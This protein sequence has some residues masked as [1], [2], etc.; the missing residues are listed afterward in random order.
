MRCLGARALRAPLRSC[1]YLPS[2]RR[3]AERLL[4]SSSCSSRRGCPWC[5][6]WD[7]EIAPIYGKTDLGRRATLRRVDISAPRPADLASIAPVRFTPTFVLTDGGAE[8][9]RI[10]GYTG[11]YQFWGLMEELMAKLKP[12]S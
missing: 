3:F 1:S 11:E 7:R 5:V 8:I 4:R 10:V 9:G 6:R 12:A 2:S